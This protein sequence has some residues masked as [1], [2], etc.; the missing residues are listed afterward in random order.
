VNGTCSQFRPLTFF[1]FQK[2]FLSHNESMKVLDLQC[3]Q[4]HQFE[5]WFASEDDFQSQLSKD[6]VECPFCADHQ[7][8]K[9]LS[10]P[11]LNL[12]ASRAS[13]NQG[14]SNDA[15]AQHPPGNEA[16]VSAQTE[17]I[18]SSS[19]GAPTQTEVASVSP[20]SLPQDVQVQMQAAWL[21]MVQH[22][23]ANTEDVGHQFADEARKMH[24]GETQE[25]NIRGQVSAEESQSL[26]EEGIAVMPLVLPSAMKGSVH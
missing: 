11:R 13:R 22:V 24:Y 10:A 14:L 9:R 4:E 26:L 7:I 16:P 5:G 23:M 25:R 17:L 19:E 18:S 15:N 20:A 6:M 3:S 21:S 8:V 12:M 1:V 2:L